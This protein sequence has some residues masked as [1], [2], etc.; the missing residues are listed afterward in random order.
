MLDG[1]APT[2]EDLAR[3]PY[4]EAVLNEAWRFYPPAWAMT[5]QAAEAVEL[6][7]YRFPAG[8][9]F[10][11]NQWVLH[12]RPDLW[13]D[14]DSF[15][16]ERWQDGQ[17]VPQGAYFPFGA[18]PR[19]CIGMPFAQMEAR[20]LLATMLQ[21]FTPQLV[22]DFRVELQPR[23]TVRPRD[24]MRMILQPTSTSGVR[25]TEGIS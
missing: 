2:V 5:R 3:L 9:V 17:K 16:P 20:L 6:D 12:R 10:M 7:G 1:R 13:G 25:A 8:T 4:L 24:G 15:R 14:P 22:P 21:R 18:G 11:V 23:V 19:I